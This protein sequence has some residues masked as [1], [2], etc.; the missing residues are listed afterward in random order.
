MKIRAM[1]SLFAF[2]LSTSSAQAAPAKAG[3]LAGDYPLVAIEGSAL[4]AYASRGLGGLTGNKDF[5]VG[6]SDFSL[7]AIVPPAT[8]LSDLNSALSLFALAPY[9]GGPMG[10]LASPGLSHAYAHLNNVTQK[11]APAWTIPLTITAGP[12]ML[13]QLLGGDYTGVFGETM[14]RLGIK[15]GYVVLSTLDHIRQNFDISGLYMGL[16]LAGTAYILGLSNLNEYWIVYQAA[17]YAAEGAGFSLTNTALENIKYTHKDS[18]LTDQ[19]QLV[20]SLGIT[21]LASMIPA[22]NPT[23]PL[24]ADR[25]K[26]GIL[27][28]TMISNVAIVFTQLPTQQAIT[29]LALPTVYAI[30]RAA[31]F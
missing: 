14:N 22:K 29:L 10:P 31:G 23:N 18:L 4:T 1:V 7:A 6:L 13:Y 28:S 21:A 12:V 3:T 17:H 16:G 25:F 11:I 8:G 5:V 9:T 20:T 15:S 19:I 26:I 30:K 24:I 2:A 27:L